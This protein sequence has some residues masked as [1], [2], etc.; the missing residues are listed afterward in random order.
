MPEKTQEEIFAEKLKGMITESEGKMTEAIKTAVKEFS[1]GNAE[2]MAEI[3]E[4]AKKQGE[5]IAAIKANAKATTEVKSIKEGLSIALKARF[6]ECKSV[7]EIK[8]SLKENP[9]VIEVKTA[10]AITI[11]GNATGTVQTRGAVVWDVAPKQIPFIREFATVSTTSNAILPVMSKSNEDGDAAWTAEGGLKPLRDFDLVVTENTAKKVAE[12]ATFSNE[13][14]QDVDMFL[15]ML[16]L[17]LIEQLNLKEE[18]GILFGTGASNDPTGVADT[19]SAFTLTSISTTDPNNLDAIRAAVAQ[20][21]SVNHYPDVAF[22]NPIDAANMDLAKTDDGAYIL[23][24]FTTAEGLKISGVRVIEK[25]QIPQGYVL[26]GNFK[27]VEI[28]DY[29]PLTIELG[30]TGDD[31][32]YNRITA[33]AEKRLHA[34]VKTNNQNAFVYDTFANIKSAITAPVA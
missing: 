23:P 1:D 30:Y 7:E 34:F 32:K 8:T 27:K 2:K 22:V 28:Y 5:E 18:N 9:L 4:I 11:S 33:R 3:M 19:A 6:A 13:I 29:Q 24:P 17:D 31:W 16:Q 20:I 10:G 26:V 15:E 21:V 14:M 12:I 25:N